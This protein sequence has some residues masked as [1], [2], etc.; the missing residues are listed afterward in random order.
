VKAGQVIG[1]LGDSGLADGTQPHVH[2]E[3]HKGGK[4]VNPYPYLNKARRLLFAVLPGPN[5]TVAL[6]G[7]VVTRTDSTLTV[8]VKTVRSWPGGLRFNVHRTVTVDVPETATVQAGG[9]DLASRHIASL[10]V[11]SKGQPVAVKTPPAPPTLSALLGKKGA[12]SASEILLS[13]A[14]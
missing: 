7:Q 14:P 10:D 8:A 4:P 2:F 6:D 5:F 9:P 1:F 11:A 3:V 12:L 13:T